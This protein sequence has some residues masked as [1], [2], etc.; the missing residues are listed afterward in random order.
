[1]PHVRRQGRL[2]S[3]PCPRLQPGQF[4]AHAGDAKDGK[5]MV[6]DQPQGEADQDRRKG[7]QPWALRHVP[8]G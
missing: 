1:M 3:A 8:A 5:A 2:P 4:Y 6:A 7:R